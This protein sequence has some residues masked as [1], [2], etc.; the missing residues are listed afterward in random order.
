MNTTRLPLLAAAL[1]LAAMTGCA[2]VPT[3]DPAYAATRPKA[4]PDQAPNSGA[5]YQQG[6]T[7]AL[8]EDRLA[9]H[10]GDVLTIRLVESTSA[11]KSASTSTKKETAVDVAAPTI[12]GSSPQFSLPERVPLANTRQ[13]NLSANVDSKQNFSGEGDSSQG[14][15]LT[16]SISVT[17]ADVLPNGNLVVRGEKLLTLNQGHEHIRI[18]GI[19]RPSDIAPDNSVVSTLV[20]DAQITYAGEGAV[21]DANSM[22]WLSRFFN[23]SW[24]PF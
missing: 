17:V 11:S 5:I 6:R 15:S 14:N 1:V 18:A 8:F 9:R 4:P 7:M 12:F 20:A 2:S 23:S 19:V 16:G 13:L 21:A 10:V 3:R 24:W 22:G